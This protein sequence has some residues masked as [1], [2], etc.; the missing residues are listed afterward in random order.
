VDRIASPPARVP[1]VEKTMTTTEDYPV[2]LYD[3]A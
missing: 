3:E 1:A 2:V